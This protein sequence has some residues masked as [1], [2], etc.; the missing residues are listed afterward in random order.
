MARRRKSKTIDELMVV[1]ITAGVL[2]LVLLYFAGTSGTTAG[3]GA[4]GLGGVLVGVYLRPWAD[5]VARRFGVRIVPVGQ[6]PGPR[7]GT[8]PDG[9]AKPKGPGE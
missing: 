6:P 4:V 5:R 2:Y 1:G 8:H 9:K 3:Y 7:T